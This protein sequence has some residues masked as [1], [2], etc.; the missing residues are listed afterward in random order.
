MTALLI[1][2]MASLRPVIVER[3]DQS[4][5]IGFSGF[6]GKLLFPNGDLKD[7]ISVTFG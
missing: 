2:S 4:A 5:N 6:S 3:R 1:G 7:K